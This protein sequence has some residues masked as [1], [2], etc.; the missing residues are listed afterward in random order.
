[1]DEPTEQTPPPF[2]NQRVCMTAT[3]RFFKS[4]SRYRS[5]PTLLFMGILAMVVLSLFAPSLRSGFV[6]DSK[7]QVLIGDFIHQRANLLP[8]LTF[9][10]IS[11]DVLD[12]NRPV[13][14]ASLMFD[15]LVWGKNPF[16]YHLTNILLHLI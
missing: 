12:F 15:S 3:K 16:G 7:L 9:Q 4:L 8:V 6:Y 11:W 13:Q 1:M 2:I 5:C 10:V 14:L